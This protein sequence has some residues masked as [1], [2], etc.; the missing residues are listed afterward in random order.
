MNRGWGEHI[1]RLSLR[2]VTIQMWRTKSSF[3]QLSPDA[4]DWNHWMLSWAI[5]KALPLNLLQNVRHSDNY[6]IILKLSVTFSS[7]ITYNYAF[8]N[9]IL[10][11]WIRLVQKSIWFKLVGWIPTNAIHNEMEF[12]FH[13]PRKIR[14][15][16]STK[17]AIMFDRM[18][19]HNIKSYF[20]AAIIWI[21]S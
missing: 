14:N 20:G 3:W 10:W 17:H 6:H 19:E 13:L 7:L 8:L 18:T 21:D 15:N 4:L 2:P 12:G 1:L 5:W 11:W 16:E 9:Y